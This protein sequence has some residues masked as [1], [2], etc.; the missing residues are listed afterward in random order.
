MNESYAK[1]AVSYFI[2]VLVIV[3]RAEASFLLEK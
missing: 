3:F 1:A 2:S